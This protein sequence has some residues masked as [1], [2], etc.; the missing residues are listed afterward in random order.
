MVSSECGV[1][2]DF[3]KPIVLRGGVSDCLFLTTPIAISNAAA[4]LDRR[5]LVL[6]VSS[7]H[8]AYHSATAGLSD[9]LLRQTSA[10]I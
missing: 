7:G 6:L 10:E 5:T 1:S 9:P 3:L 2:D 4:G 8:R